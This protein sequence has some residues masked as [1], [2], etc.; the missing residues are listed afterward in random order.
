MKSKF[1]DLI[2]SVTQTMLPTEWIIIDDE[3]VD[4]TSDV[5]FNLS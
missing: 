2:N 3:S 4:S 1:P 5:A